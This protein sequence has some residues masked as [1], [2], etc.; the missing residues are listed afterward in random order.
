MKKLI[1]L[2]FLPLLIMG[3]GVNM[4]KQ[5]DHGNLTVFFL[6]GVSTEK[7]IEFVKYWD[8][9]GFI[10]DRKQ[11]IQLESKDGVILVNIIERKMYQDDGLTITE[12]AMLQQLGRD[13]EKAVFHKETAIVITD[14]TFR[15]IIKDK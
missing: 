1:V 13:L 11:T 8:K 4:G 3:C 5:I 9:H 14:N 7:A 15:P 10:G 12:E 6:E 2:L